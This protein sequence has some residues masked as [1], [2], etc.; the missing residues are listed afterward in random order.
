MTVTV[1][2][3]IINIMHVDYLLNLSNPFDW[4]YHN[5]HH[6]LEFSLCSNDVN[7]LIVIRVNTRYFQQTG[8]RVS[9]CGFQSIFYKDDNEV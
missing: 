6:T 7:Y 2:S 8:I 4:L 9:Y 3:Q 1:L 5:S